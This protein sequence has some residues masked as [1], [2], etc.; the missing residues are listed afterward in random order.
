MAEEHGSFSSVGLVDAPATENP[1]ILFHTAGS[2][3]L[4]PGSTYRFKVSAMN[5]VGEGEISDAI[6]VIAA[7]VP[8]APVNAPV[9]TL[10]TETSVSLSIEALTLSMDG[11]APVT[12]Y[13][14]EMDDGDGGDFTVIHDSLT[15]QLI[16]NGLQ[17]GTTYR[18]RYAAR[19]IVYDSGNLY[20][21]DH[22]RYSPSVYVLTAVGPSKPLNLRFDP[23]IRYKNA[24]VYRWDAPL[25]T[26]G[27]P[28]QIYTLELETVDSGDTSLHSI[29]VQAHSYRF[30]ELDSGKDYSVRIKVTNLVDESDWTDAVTARTGIVPTRPG[31]LTFDST[32]RTTIDASFTGLTGADTGGTDEQP[33]EVTYYHVY[34]DSGSL[35]TAEN[36]LNDDHSNFKLL[37]SLPGSQTSFTAS[38][39]VPHLTY[40][41]KV[42]AE[43]SIG[44][45]S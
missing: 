18:F 20:E 39:L 1:T 28:L 26:G 38:Y 30:S 41:F 17:V 40:R 5:I 37:T 19:N 45:L 33:L 9:A 36:M 14:V 2:A 32:T 21:S 3:S 4:V 43:N 13:L 42:Q 31:I 11:G 15:L 22:L 35:S 7:D 44:L 23:T 27:S 10:I 25:S 16:V 24:L 8:D 34:I 12:G 29:T 6:S